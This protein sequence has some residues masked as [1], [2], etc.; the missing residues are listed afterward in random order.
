MDTHLL[1]AMYKTQRP[2]TGSQPEARNT[3]AMAQTWHPGNADAS[4]P[5]SPANANSQA[6]LLANS[7]PA[8]LQPQSSVALSAGTRSPSATSH[9]PSPMHLEGSV[10]ASP[11]LPRLPGTSPQASPEPTSALQA[12]LRPSTSGSAQGVISP[13]DATLKVSASPSP[14]HEASEIPPLGVT[15]SENPDDPQGDP[16][17]QRP[18]TTAF[19]SHLTPRAQ[20]LR[21]EEIDRVGSPP[22]SQKARR[23]PKAQATDIHTLRK[24]VA[25]LEG[26]FTLPPAFEAYATPRLVKSL[27]VR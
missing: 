12:T 19:G 13:A 20:M 4:Q 11:G 23:R 3:L 16:S 8:G 5:T 27:D 1:G 26:Q 15:Q 24:K 25:A 9:A 18:V 22:R 7:A 2:G 21:E 10:A 6:K 17:T 14:D